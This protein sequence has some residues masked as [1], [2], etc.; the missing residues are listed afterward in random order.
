MITV[1]IKDEGEETVTRMTYENLYKELKDVPGSDLIVVDNWFDAVP[2]A[3]KNLYVCFVEADCLVNSGYFASQLGLFKKN[4]YFR[5]LAM[6]SSGTGVNNWGNKFYG[7]SLGN[8]YSD[9]IIPNTDKKSNTVYPIQVGFVPGSIIRVSMLGK[10]MAGLKYGNA[11]QD[12]LVHLSTVLSLAFWNQ[13]DGNRV[14]INPN[15]TYVST[16]DYINGLG[17]PVEEAKELKDKFLRESI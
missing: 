7:Y 5:K 10:V 17:K 8:S 3:K 11:L 2:R 14:H 9:G 1:A 6:L 13:G 16:E 15:T 12:D 4:P